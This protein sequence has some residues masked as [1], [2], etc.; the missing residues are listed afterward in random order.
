MRALLREFG[1]L[2]L[3]A[4]L[5]AF[6]PFFVL[7][8]LGVVWLWH[9]GQLLVWF[10]VTAGCGFLGYGLHWLSRLYS[11]SQLPPA[12]GP[13]AHW[14][15]DSHEAWQHVEARASEAT[16]EQYPLSDATGLFRLGR[17]T[18]EDVA[19]HY[20]PHRERPLLELTV[21]HM[22]LIIERASRELRADIV[23]HVP[24]S[25]RLTLGSM[26]RLRRWRDTAVRLE[27]LYRLG[28]AAVDPT[29]VVFRE[30]RRD[31]GNRV[32]GYGSEQVQTWLLREYIRKVGYYAIELY[33][34]R[35]L[36]ASET[37]VESVTRASQLQQ[38]ESE[39]RPE[40][41]EPLRILLLG[42][43]N[44]GRSSLVNALE[45]EP[46]AAVDSAAGTTGAI[47][48]YS[49]GSSDGDEVLLIDTPGVEGEAL[50]TATLRREV[51]GA[52]LVLWV[53]PALRADREG[54][55]AVLERIRDW[56]REDPSR[57]P[58]PLI[59]VVTGVDAV[60]PA[61]EWAPPYT[62]A[63]P[64]TPK[65]RNI[66][67]AVEAVGG[68]LEFDARHRVGVSLSG[69]APFNVTPGLVGLMEGQLD[70]A[71]RIRLL[72]CLRERRRD[73]TWRYLWRQVR[74]AGQT[75]LAKARE[76]H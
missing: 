21:P 49:W 8:A 58:P 43:A 75:A 76:R 53:T 55:R 33:S 7:P 47:E 6:L 51:L 29:S 72:R 17:D 48:A 67:A 34:G 46:V 16:P 63:E 70:E 69:D 3:L 36:L 62:L 12:T 24:L 39:G 56:F 18:V 30:L 14:P 60:R 65:A 61:R 54:E 42:R 2:R 66:V 26:A 38:Q 1:Y 4:V 15:P 44:S 9:S 32:L 73:E 23:D 11:R 68:E 5:I 37:P 74:N 13:E 28:H 20:H 19:R 22:L 71:R 52:D 41:S 25:H 64:A 57:R 45:G 35:L 27:G 31:L 40:S 50:D 10:L 59:G